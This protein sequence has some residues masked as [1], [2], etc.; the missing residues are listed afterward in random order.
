VLN[1]WHVLLASVGV[2]SA[3]VAFSDTSAHEVDYEAVKNAIAALLKNESYDDGSYGPVFVRLAWHCAGTYDKNDQSGG[4]NG[5]TMRFEPESQHGANAGLGVARDLLEPLMAQFPGLTYADL[6][7]LAGVVAIESLGGPKI[8]WTHGRTDATSGESCPPNGRL[9]DAVQGQDH[10]R[11]IF[12][13]MGFNDREIVAL[14]GAHALGRC[15]R[16]RSGFEGPWT[17]SPTHFSNDYYVQLLERTWTERQWDGP[18]QFEDEHK[19]LMMLPAD[20]SLL[21]DEQFSVW[22]RAYAEDQDLFFADFAEAFGKLLAL[23]APQV[24]IHAHK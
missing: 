24:C 13:R 17:A 10:I 12:Y 9:P 18:K 16:D 5:G 20:L 11:D 2:A 7:T 4:S 8:P 14:C 15:H 21:Q 23:G 19:Q 1:K 6:Y 22:V 3:L